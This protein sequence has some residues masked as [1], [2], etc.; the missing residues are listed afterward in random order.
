MKV[1]L[2]PGFYKNIKTGNRYI[3]QGTALDVTANIDR[4]MVVY[5]PVAAHEIKLLVRELSEFKQKFIF[6][7][8]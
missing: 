5:M 1:G 6:E 3:V 7:E 2:K 8:P 4:E